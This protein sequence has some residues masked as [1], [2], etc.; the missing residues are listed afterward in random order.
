[1]A[2]T[3]S[4]ARKAVGHVTLAGAGPGDPSLLTIGAREALEAADVV[5]YDAL[6]SPRLLEHCPS[7][8]ECI[9]V[10]KRAGQHSMTQDEINALIV[11]KALEGKHVVRLKGGDPFVF[12]RGGEEALA[13]REAGIPFSVIPGVTS[14]VA[15][16]AY[17]G[18]AV[19]QRGLARNFAVVTGSEMSPDS[20]TDWAALARMDT[21]VVLMGAAALPEVSRKLIEAGRSPS[22]PAASIS[23]GTL[24]NQRT[25]IADLGTIA[26]R[27]QAEKMP[28]PLITVVGEVAA[29]AT[30]LAWREARPLAGKSVVVTRTRRQVSQLRGLLEE[31]GAD[32]VEAPVLEIR[33]DASELTTDERLSSRWDWI[34][35]SSQN[36]VEAFFG[37]LRTAGRDARTLGSTQIAA[38][39]SATAAALERHGIIPDF[40]PSTATG[41]CLAAELPRVSGAR[42]LLPAGSLSED[43]LADALRARGGHI[44]QVRVYETFPAA[45]DERLAERV[46]TADAITFASASSARFLRH[47]LGERELP[48]ATKLCTIG[49]QAA[50]A[51]RDVFGRVDG[52][53]AQPSIDGLV[54]SV[55][56]ALR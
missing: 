43:R 44:E 21:L 20:S 56:E 49:P 37:A 31:L 48:A 45:L 25:V 34:V 26:E 17:V 10:G 16:P 35:F 14:A 6:M 2:M 19:T 22:I 12:G 51:T 38:I 11:S 7:M 28:T 53:A 32:V 1:M 8:A 41:D 50:S 39:G 24:P 55:L 40:L 33:H 4:G 18:I 13:C 3:E 5:L 36:A 23:N 29:L 15:V 42:I 27:V 52:V 54:A 9:S 47:A 46:L 30:S